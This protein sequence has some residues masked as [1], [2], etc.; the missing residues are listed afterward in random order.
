M[1][2][3]LCGLAGTNLLGKALGIVLRLV[4]ISSEQR[5]L[6]QA[7]FVLDD[8]RRNAKS[9]EGADEDALPVWEVVAGEL[10]PIGSFEELFE[11][12]VLEMAAVTYLRGRSIT[13]EIVIVDDAS[14][15]ETA[16]IAEDGEIIDTALATTT[17]YR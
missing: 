11:R 9:F 4:G 1:S 2:R 10:D 17:V 12:D 6:L 5:V 7:D 3:D 13:G 14:T 16:T 15:D 8:H